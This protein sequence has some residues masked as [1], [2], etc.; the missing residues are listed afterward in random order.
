MSSMGT[1]RKDWTLGTAAVDSSAYLGLKVA[2]F[3]GT[4]GLGRAISE[5]LLAEGA[6]VTVFG[7]SMKD[8]PHPRRTFI[9]ADFSSL[10]E[11]QAV[12]QEFAAETFD[13]AILTHGI[14]AGPIRE[15]T[16]E[17]VEKDLATSALSRWVI[18]GELARRLGRERPSGRNKPRIFVWG[19]P[20]GERMVD[21][22]DVQSKTHYRWQTAHGNTVVFNEA[23]VHDVAAKLPEVNIFGMNPGIIKTNIMA[24]VLGGSSLSLRLQQAVVGLLFQSAETYAKAILPLLVH[25]ELE[26]RSGALFNRH[27]KPILPNPWLVKEANCDKVVAAADAIVDSVFAPVRNNRP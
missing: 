16:S 24:G 27:A 23:L 9:R 19:F 26:R 10:K 22:A 8:A 6:L 13:A 4:G 18:V 15:V 2:I 11:S 12:A 25:P 5:A 20:G 3:G 7:R 21:L 14:F 1:V 17:G